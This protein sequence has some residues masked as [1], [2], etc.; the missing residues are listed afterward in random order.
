MVLKGGPRTSNRTHLECLDF[1]IPWL[2]LD[3]LSLGTARDSVLPSPQGGSE[4][5]TT[6][7]LSSK[8][9][10]L[11]FLSVR[12]INTGAEDSQVW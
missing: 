2:L 6:L 9:I 12:H 8:S 1:Q 4:S 5:L 7:A 10:V 11:L 3:L